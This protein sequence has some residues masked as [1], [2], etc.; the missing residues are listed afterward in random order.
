MK[1]RP[2]EPHLFADDAAMKKLKNW[3]LNLSFFYK[4]LILTLTVSIVSMIFVAVFTF[5]KVLDIEAERG[6]NE[7]L[8]GLIWSESSINDDLGEFRLQCIKVSMDR[9]VYSELKKSGD[10]DERNAILLKKNL[11]DINLSGKSHSAFLADFERVVLSNTQ[12]DLLEKKVVEQLD[13]FITGL[14]STAKPYYFG[15]PIN[16]ENDYLI[17]YVRWIAPSSGLAPAGVLVTNYPENKLQSMVHDGMNRVDI[18]PENVLIV[19]DSTVISSWDKELIGRNIDSIVTD[20]GNG[21]SGGTYKGNEAIFINY[22]NPGKSDWVYVAIVT[23][24]E[25]FADSVEV[26][27]AFILVNTIGLVI[28]ILSSYFVSLNISKPLKYLSSAMLEAGNKNL[29]IEIKNPEY[30]DEIGR[31]WQSLIA[32]TEMLKASNEANRRAQEQNQRLKIEALKAQINPHFL[33]NTFGSIIYL[34]DSGNGHEATE[35]LS[36]LSGLLHISYDK[37]KEYVRVEE[38]IGLVRRY[39]DIQKIR[40]NGGFSFLFDVDMDIMPLYT[41]KI[42]LQPVV[43]NAISHGMKLCPEKKGLIEISG[44][45]EGDLLVFEVSDNFGALTEERM[46]EVNDFLRSSIPAPV[47]VTGIGLKNVNDRICYEF[48]QD[49]RLGVRLEIRGTKTVSI[50]TSRIMELNDEKV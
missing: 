21:F 12:S 47:P 44:R 16:I 17:P 13:S 18:R 1:V 14:R 23:K 35:M 25:M 37:S 31:M 46:K 34:I 24:N 11:F 36:S 41:V 22:S 32:M 30:D 33:Y 38:E 4:I 19:N 45:R 43:E 3:Y 26:I 9:E 15:T 40:Y 50:I 5:R 20:S 7:I 8:N 48:P 49:G 10:G 28:I 6:R 2:G 42:I 27:R 29:D 39:L